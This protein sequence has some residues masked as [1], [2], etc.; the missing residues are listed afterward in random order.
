MF[1]LCLRLDDYATDTTLLASDMSMSIATYVFTTC[2]PRLSTNLPYPRINPLFKSMGTSVTL[3]PLART[4]LVAQVAKSKAWDWQ[5]SNGWVCRTQPQKPNARYS[6]CR[7]CFPRTGSNARVG[8]TAPG[9]GL[10]V[11]RLFRVASRGAH[12]R[13]QKYI[14]RHFAFHLHLRRSRGGR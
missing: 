11:P 6:R 14:R 12:A 10:R 2:C 1:A 9:S 3:V 13:H 8:E 4:D 7:W 5:I